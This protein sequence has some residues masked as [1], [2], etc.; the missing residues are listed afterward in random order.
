MTGT[1]DI[2]EDEVVVK[3]AD[4]RLL[5]PPWKDELDAISSFSTMSTHQSSLTSTS[6]VQSIL[7]NPPSQPLQIHHVIPT[8]QVIIEYA[9]HCV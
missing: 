1:S 3:R 5:Y 9:R 7:H 2:Q 4:I 6:N 8:L